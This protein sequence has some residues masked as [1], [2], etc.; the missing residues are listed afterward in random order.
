MGHKTGKPKA[1][2]FPYE[3]YDAMDVPLGDILR[4]ER[5]TVGKS[6]LDVER[7][8][9]IKASYIAAIENADLDAFTS[10][11][12]IAGYVRS[13]ARYLGL[14]PEWT[15]SRF[16]RESG[17]AGVHGFSARQAEQAKRKVAEAPGRI[18][19]NDLISAARVA[20]AP[21]K[22][23][24]F[25]RIEPGA[26]GSIAVLAAVVIGIGYGAWAIL[27]DIQRLNFAPVDEA[28]TTYADFDPIAG[29]GRLAAP[30][31]GAD[32][33]GFVLADEGIDRSYRP[34]AL[35][36]PVMTPRDAP[37]ATLNPDH[38]GT[39]VLTDT[40][41]TE[42]AAVEEVAETDPAALPGAEVQVTERDGDEV[43][44]FAVRPSWIRVSSAS[45]TVIFEG[46]LDSGDSFTLP[47][48]EEPP[49]LRAGNS[50]SLY[51][52]VNGV[53]MGPA[54]PG[55][56]IAR[57]VVLSADAISENYVFADA[58][59]DPELAPVAALVLGGSE[60]GEAPQE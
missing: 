39:L 54:G 57:D 10:R 37:L 16:S 9:K 5:A 28:P 6:L 23:R 60:P 17:F 18:D 8:L 48:T 50:G 13:Y 22:E 19:P 35:E 45:G 25:D 49:T 47:Q 7:D 38:V 40:G 58:S 24:L 27:H 41:A 21:A 14:D 4:G 33:P 34:E 26:L 29:A 3:E 2:R 43:V 31:V 53:T 55:T 46:T 30:E 12:F 15:Y 42:I 44:L 51:F 20:F 36:L 32:G 56:S 11:G 59:A 1:Q 52:A